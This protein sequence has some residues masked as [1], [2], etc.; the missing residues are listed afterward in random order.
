MDPTVYAGMTGCVTTVVLTLVGILKAKFPKLRETYTY[1]L[2]AA[3]SYVIP[4]A[5]AVSVGKAPADVVLQGLIVGTLAWG[6]S[7]GTA[8][9]V[10]LSPKA[11]D[12]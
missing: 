2:A 3:F 1:L 12:K 7:V 4:T 8:R 11:L 6:A 5:H 10:R 9:A